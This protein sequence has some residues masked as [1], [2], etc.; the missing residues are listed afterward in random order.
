MPVNPY[1][2][3][4][5]DVPIGDG[6][7]GA[8][9]AATAL[10]NLGGLDE[11]A[12][13]LLDHAG[14][15]GVGDL[16]ASAHSM[17]DHG[18]Y[19]H[20]LLNVGGATAAVATGDLA[21][22][23]GTR[24]IFWDSSASTLFMNPDE[25]GLFILQGRDATSSNTEG[26]DVTLI[27]GA[28]L[29]SGT[30]GVVAL[31]GGPAGATGA[32]GVISLLGGT[33]TDGDGGAVE[34]YAADGV[35]TNR[36]GGTITITAGASTGTTTGGMATITA[37]VGG[38]TGAGGLLN[39]FGGAGGATS[40]TA[41]GVQITGGTP[42]DG[43]GGA[44]TI[45]GSN[46]VGTNRSGGNVSLIGGAATG[47]GTIGRV[48]FT[49]GGTS[50]PLTATGTGPALTTT[51][52]TIIEAINEVD[53][54]TGGAP[55][56]SDVLAV[57]NT[58]G[59]NDIE[60][61]AAQVVRGVNAA[62]GLALTLRGGNSSGTATGGAALLRGGTPTDGD[63]G[64]VELYAANGVGTDRAGGALTAFAGNAS[65]TATG[66]QTSIHSGDGGSG[67]G[68]G[69]N[70][71]IIS[72]N[73]G[74]GA[75]AGEIT[76]SGGSSTAGFAGGVQISGG[77]GSSSASGGHC[78]LSGGPGGATGNGGEVSITS[79]NGGATSGN[80]GS[81]SLVAGTAAGSGSDAEIFFS[82]GGTTRLRI[83]NTGELRSAGTNGAS[84]SIQ[85]ASTLLSGLSGASVSASS[86]VPDGALI[87]AVTVRVTTT[88]TGATTFDI[89][90][91]TDVDRWGA[92]IALA[93]GTT[94]DPT[95]YTDNTISFQTGGAG[96]VVLTA[97]GSNF[98]G[99][100]VR[101]HLTYMSFTG[102]TG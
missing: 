25:A 41:G 93:S 28:G 4:G 71:S 70:I 14:L 88:I 85:H 101:V 66:G 51:A 17:I 56:L 55:S 3:G 11:T 12:H 100:D 69:G 30:G 52:Q 53:A 64:A 18:S 83:T 31:I 21:A 90:D 43:N 27:G 7:T 102:P 36:A 96:N 37:G 34:L 23:D 73:G 9:V 72:G 33:P 94:T 99:G 67:G 15:T 80:A 5:S 97:N 65:G 89:G 10:S 78:N 16:T 91:G 32:G 22:G 84:G 58:T 13:D 26:A 24:S 44:V 38:A 6:G 87:L 92:A 2:K 60:I 82:T 48:L 98:S 59:A 57:G 29:G 79:G 62:T 68:L 54:A 50:Y 81:L 76:V 35:G 75:S 42:A 77:S 19:T 8:S 46:G 40:G 1:I 61:A 20:S 39:L 95:D 49:S 45:L 47:S 74:G 63:G 86:L